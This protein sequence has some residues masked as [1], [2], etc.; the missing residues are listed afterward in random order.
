MQKLN[1]ISRDQP[2]ILAFF[3][4]ATSLLLAVLVLILIAAFVL[5]TLGVKV[6]RDMLR[7]VV[8]ELRNI[9]GVL[10]LALT[11]TSAA[12]SKWT[13]SGRASLGP[14]DRQRNGRKVA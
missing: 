2:K 7:L 10:I 11:A 9:L 5:A 12:A 6:D 1:I 4:K 13:G 8:E 14:K 3:L